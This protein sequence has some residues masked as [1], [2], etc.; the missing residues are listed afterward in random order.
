M[1]QIELRRGHNQVQP[2]A[3]LWQADLT[4]RA[5]RRHGSGLAHDR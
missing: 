5:V 4:D 3:T 2:M 1:E